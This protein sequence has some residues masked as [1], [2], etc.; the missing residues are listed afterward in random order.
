MII[1]I[2]GYEYS[3]IHRLCLHLYLPEAIEMRDTS[4]VLGFPLPLMHLEGSNQ[5]KKIIRA[6]YNTQKAIGLFKFCID[7]NCKY[8]II[9]L[10]MVWSYK[11]LFIQ[12]QR[13]HPKHLAG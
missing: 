5:M 3:Q 13:M 9:V 4:G 6:M 1:S 7:K 8:M 12:R 11:V 10:L 2:S